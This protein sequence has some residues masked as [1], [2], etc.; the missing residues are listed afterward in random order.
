MVPKR[1]NI[2]HIFCPTD[3]SSFS[4][5]A[6]ERAAGAASW[7]G[8]RLTLLH[9]VPPMMGIGPPDTCVPFVVAPVDLL[10]VQ[11]E[12]AVTDLERLAV[13]IRARGLQVATKVLVGDPSREIEAAAEALPAD[14]I[15]MGTH[16]R[17]GFEHLVMGSVAEKMLRRAPC[18]VLIVGNDVKPSGRSPLFQRILCA[19]DLTEASAGTVDMAFSLAEEN[20]AKVTMLHVVESLAGEGNALLGIPEPEAISSTLVERATAGLWRMMP[21][22]LHFRERVE[23][24]TAWRTILRVAQESASD[25]IVLGAHARGGFGRLFLGSTANQVVRHAHCPVLVIREVRARDRANVASNPVEAA[26]TS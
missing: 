21:P 7:F 19:V 18:P 5:H 2:T 10:R 17:G 24:G 14:L 26:A 9:V 8:A 25:L 22:A 3:F 15:V 1:L 13:P 23:I 20:Q 6:M 4:E 16:G 11:Q 12:A